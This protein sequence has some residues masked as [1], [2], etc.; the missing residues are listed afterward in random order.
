M[1]YSATVLITCLVVVGSTEAKSI[2]TNGE[3]DVQPVVAGALLGIFLFIFGLINEN[4]AA[5][6]CI[7]IAVGSII[8]NGKHLINAL[9]PR[10]VVMK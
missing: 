6:L 2:S 9:T 8:L 10:K 1:D 3:F 7:L 4:L 5:R